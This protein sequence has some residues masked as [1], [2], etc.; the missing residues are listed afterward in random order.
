MPEKQPKER[1]GRKQKKEKGGCDKQQA[2]L[3]YGPGTHRDELPLSRFARKTL[4]RAGVANLADFADKP[5]ET[6]IAEGHSPMAFFE[7]A[8]LAHEAGAVSQDLH[9]PALS[10]ANTKLALAALVRMVAQRDAM[11]GNDKVA[12]F[13]AILDERALSFLRYF[14]ASMKE[15]YEK[16]YERT[17]KP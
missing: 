14:K 16:E 10:M 12:G 15:A 13:Q 6:W 9:D 8:M 17:A 5:I 2:P 3:P 4:Q 1:K 7:A 11:I